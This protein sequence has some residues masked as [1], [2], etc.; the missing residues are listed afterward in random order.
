[1]AKVHGEEM[2]VKNLSFIILLSKLIFFF[3]FNNVSALLK[4]LT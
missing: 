1:M 4:I 3:N 2:T